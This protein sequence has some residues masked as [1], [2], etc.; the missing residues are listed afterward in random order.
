MNEQLQQLEASRHHP[1][2]QV[3][4]EQRPAIVGEI[5]HH[6]MRPYFLKR[7]PEMQAKFGE[8][9]YQAFIQMMADYCL[10]EYIEN[11]EPR[12]TIEFI[13]G[14][15]RTFYYNAPSVPMTAVD[16]TKGTIVPG[17]FKTI[18]VSVWQGSEW[19]ATPAPETVHRDM[20]RLLDYLHDEGVPLFQR[21]IQSMFEFTA[22][23]PFPDSNGKIALVLGD[24]FLLKQ[25][26]HPP[27]FA[28]YRWQNKDALYSEAARFS[29]GAER[30]ISGVYSVVLGLYAECGLGSASE[31]ESADA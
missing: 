19:V 27:F 18:S 17:E 28:K 9:Q 4:P 12:L 29:I 21:Y 8:P 22:I 26:I 1:S 2:L 11:P 14:L 25:G 16:G 24:L 5:L 31:A 7:T 10:R 15:H 3:A 23:H 13:K 20:A 6:L 30:D